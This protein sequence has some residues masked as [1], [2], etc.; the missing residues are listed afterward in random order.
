MTLQPA[1]LLRDHLNLLTENPLSG[2]ILDLACGDGHNGIFLA[3]H[4]LPVICCDN[5][6]AALDRA[7]KSAEEQGVTVTLWQVDLE[8]AGVN[9]LPDD[10]YVSAPTAHTLHQEGT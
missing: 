6:Q 1:Q 7:R 10:S 5:S 4:H 3:T 2:P 9:P 8:R